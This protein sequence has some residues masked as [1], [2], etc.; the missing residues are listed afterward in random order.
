VGKDANLGLW[1][2]ALCHLAGATLSLRSGHRLR[3]T[4]L[5]LGFAYA[6]ALGVVG[7]L[8]LAVSRLW[9]PVFFVPGPS[10]TAS[11]WPCRSEANKRPRFAPINR[12]DPLPA[13]TGCI[14]FQ[15]VVVLL[16]GSVVLLADTV[17]NIGD[18]ATAATP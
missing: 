5:W 16:R 15:I 12:N 7:L 3:A 10:L 4:G 18:V 6:L 13:Y 17:H 1:L 2:A 14:A 8:A 11:G 9:L